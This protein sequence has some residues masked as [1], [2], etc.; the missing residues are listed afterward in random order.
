MGAKPVVIGHVLRQQTPEMLLVQHDNML[1][2]VPAYTANHPL[3]VWILPR[4]PWGDQD[5]FDPE[6]SK[7]S[8]SSLHNG[9]SPVIAS[10]SACI[11]PRNHQ[12]YTSV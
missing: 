9:C 1:E 10:S 12:Y 5:F 7:Y 4:T 6:W 11:L 2:H 8:N 3:C